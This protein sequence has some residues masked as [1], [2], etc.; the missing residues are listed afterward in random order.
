MLRRAV[1]IQMA[2]INGTPGNDKLTGGNE[3]DLVNGLAGNDQLNGG[4][5]ND[6]INGGDGDDEM[7][8]DD[9]N[10]IINGGAGNDDIAGGAGND[11]M[12]GGKGDDAYFVDSAKDV[13]SE[14]ANQGRDQVNSSISFTLGANVEDLELT[15]D[16]DINGT[17]NTL[18][19]EIE[20]NDKNNRLDGGAGND[21][22]FGGAGNDTLIGGAGNDTLT[23]GVGNDVM[24]GGA[25]NDRMFWNPGDGSDV[26][27]GGFGFDIAVVDGAAGAETFTIAADGAGVRFDRTSAATFGIDIRATERLLVN[28]GAGD[29]VFTA[30][31]DL[32]ARIALTLIGGAGNDTI[33]GGNGNDVLQ[34][35]ADNDI[36]NG[37]DGNDLLLGDDGDDKMAGGKGNDLYVV[38]DDLD[39][40]TENANEGID[41]VESSVNFTLG[42]NVE[43]LTLTGADDIIGTGNELANIIEANNAGNELSGLDGNDTISGGNGNDDIFGDDGNDTLNGGAGNDFLFGG[44]DNDTLNGNDGDDTLIGGSGNDALNGGDGNDNFDGEAGEG[45][46]KMTGGKGDDTYFVESAKDAVI[47]IANQGK[48][49]VNSFISHTLSANV[50]NLNLVAGAGDINGTGNALSNVIVGNDGKNRLDGGA[51]NDTID[52]GGGNDTMLGGAGS[53]TMIWSPGG[54]S[55]V[56]DGGTGIDTAVVNGG[57]VNETFSVAVDGK[58]GVRFDRTDPTAFFIDIRATEKLVVNAG[59]G[60]DTFTADDKLA[61]LIALTVNGDAGNDTISGGNGNDLIDGGADDDTLNGNAGNDTLK[62]GLGGD[63]MA[64]GAGNDI[65]FV[66]SENDEVTENGKEGIDR[67]VSEAIAHT[68][69]ANVE[70]LTLDGAAQT[71]IGN[72]LNNVIDGNELANELGGLEGNDT[73]NGNGGNDFLDGGDGNDMLNGGDGNDVLNDEA[74]DNKMTGGKGDDIY[75]VDSAK[76]AIIELANQGKDTV[77]SAI[78]HTLSANVENLGLLAGFGDINGTGN[79][80]N[81]VIVGNDGKNRLDGGAGNDTIDGGGGNDTMLGGAGSDTMIWSPGGADDLMDGGTGVD[82]AVVNGGGV[83]ETFTVAAAGTGV[84]F[85]RINAPFFIDIRATERLEVNAGDGNDSFTVNGNLAGRI[86]LIVNGDAGNDTLNGGDGNDTLNG[87]ADDDVLNGGAGNDRLEGGTGSN[88]LAGG[89]G[90]DTYIVTNAGDDIVENANEGIDTVQSS[91]DI[92]LLANVE[93]LTLI[94]T[95][96]FGQGNDLANVINGNTEDNFL[97][98]GIGND[99]LNGGAGNDALFGEDDNDALNG[100]AGNDVLIGGIGDDKMN[101]GAGDDTYVVDSAKDVVT[102]SANQGIDTV[103]SA[104]SFTLGANLE[105]LELAG[106][107]DINGTGNSLRNV[108]EGNAG[109]NRLDGGAGNDEVDGG[110]GNDTLIGGAGNDT[111]IGGQGAD[112]MDGGIGKDVFVYGVA[113]EADLATLGGDIINGFQHGQDRIDLSDLLSDFGIDAADAFDGGFL[114]IEVV[115]NN[116]NILFDAD[117]G[118]DGFLTLAT[119]NN[120]RNVTADD[121]ITTTPL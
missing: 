27:E 50:E 115:G 113:F 78:S 89:T 84:R 47:E 12:T 63:K 98:G 81:N 116:T 1:E 110:A 28:A 41:T 37:G 95:A 120:V 54:A 20:G 106:D 64:G 45:D 40:V 97:G 71:G 85:D 108:I 99:T 100:G 107:S 67:V 51:G 32:A 72:E 92:A 15:G 65:Y 39:T 24:Q 53:D 2:I 79:T 6:T 69:A 118:G 111:L 52:G 23:G 112:V 43:N 36:L 80:L 62:G 42:A 87:G 18:G 101:G 29:D 68:L 66:D 88:T 16:Q 56:M 76:D 104:I 35:G 48:D 44:D 121:L 60:D 10:D 17:G 91:I 7:G 38:T 96:A 21:E 75:R 59:A 103:V 30:T 90:N 105:N 58:G 4:A 119:L 33:S 70:N 3:S 5:G 109:R 102:E 31:G 73:L 9:G 13:V 49:T 77:F 22:I 11:R 83:N 117:G 74:G 46:D 26:M 57:G 19:N 114:K 61:A 94:G 34:G 25:G 14:S 8:G 82:T 86:A 55:D 93:N